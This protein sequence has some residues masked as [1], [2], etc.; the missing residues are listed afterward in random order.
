MTVRGRLTGY[1]VLLA[2]FVLLLSGCTTLG[3]K[4]IPLEDLK[5]KY[6]NENSRFLE[7]DGMNIHY[8]DEGSGPVLVLIHGVCASLH[9]WDGWV[10]DL[11]DHYR[12]IRMDLPGFG[13]TPLKDKNVYD[14]DQGVRLMDEFAAK[15]GLDHFYL[16]GNSLGGY[17]A[18][19]YT[20]AHPEKVDKLILIDSAGFPS[21]TPFVLRF[22]S[23]PLIRPF[24]RR[25]MPKFMFDNAVR[26]VYGDDSRITK[27]TRDRYFELAMRKGAKSDYVD[28]FT[29][30]KRELS[31]P[32]VSY[33]ID[34]ITVPTLVMWGDKDIWLPYK[35]NIVKWRQALP[36][37]KFIIYKG[38]GHIPMEEIPDLTAHDADLFLSGK[39]S[40]QA[41]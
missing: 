21:K 37:A 14:R 19:I 25:M 11:K 29:V 8:R 2:I 5:K 13:L 22:A 6:A 17:L 32:E 20:Y 31:K 10:M 3:I 9:T 27:E 41:K 34:R 24:A 36:N 30:L 40:P 1:L 23:F 15:L 18:W 7:L 38:V 26:Q 28:I 35:E 4:S 39:T 33:G 12:I 16:A